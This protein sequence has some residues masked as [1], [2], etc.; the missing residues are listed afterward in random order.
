MVRAILQDAQYGNG[1]LQKK[2]C[3]RKWPGSQAFQGGFSDRQNH[4]QKRPNH[5]NHH[6]FGYPGESGGG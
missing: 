3:H 2:S 6:R 5:P 4:F 1:S